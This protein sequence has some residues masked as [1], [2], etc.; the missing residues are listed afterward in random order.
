MEHGTIGQKNKDDLMSVYK[1]H[2]KVLNP[3]TAIEEKV[4]MNHCMEDSHIQ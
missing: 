3:I 4:K 2:E 1:G